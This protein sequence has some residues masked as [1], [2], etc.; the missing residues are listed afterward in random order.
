[1]VPQA[2]EQTGNCRIFDKI[3]APVCNQMDTQSVYYPMIYEQTRFTALVNAYTKDLYRY[4][5]W[6]CHDR[7]QSN[8]LVQETF[9]RAWK[10]LASLRNDDAAR[11]WLI[12]ILRR[13]HARTFEKQRPQTSDVD[14][15]NIIEAEQSYDTSTE[16]YVLRKALHKMSNELREPLVLQVIHGHSCEEIAKILDLS[17]PAVMTRLFRARTFLRSILVEDHQLT[18]ESTQ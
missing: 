2:A 13:E 9:A 14:Y 3:F 12:T 10:S 5:Y 15:E 4:A 17:K 6:L 11:G 1:M 16:A 7:E 18:R 8:D